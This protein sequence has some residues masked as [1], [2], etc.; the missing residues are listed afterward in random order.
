[1]AKHNELGKWGEELAERYLIGKGYYIRD[2][3]WKFGKRD[4][5]IIAVSEQQNLLVFVEVKTRQDDKF[6]EPEAAVDLRKIRNLGIAANAYIKEFALDYEIRFD[7]L[8]IVGTE[9]AHA[10]I[11]HTENA[12]NPLLL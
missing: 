12:F 9:A 10:R 8:T 1:M 6:I 7:I 11:E 3:D 4:L 5:D 2:H